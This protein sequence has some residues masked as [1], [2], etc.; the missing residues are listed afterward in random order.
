LSRPLND[1]L[2]TADGDGGEELAQV[3]V[4]IEHAPDAIVA[5]DVDLGCITSVNAAAE[6]LFGMPRARLLQQQPQRSRPARRRRGP[7]ARTWRSR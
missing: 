5:L 1:D 4:L 7:E 6:Q 3:R 2:T